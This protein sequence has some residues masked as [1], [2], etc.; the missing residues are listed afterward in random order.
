M[1]FLLE[2]DDMNTLYMDYRKEH[3]RIAEFEDVLREERPTW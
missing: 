3:A 1:R 2:P